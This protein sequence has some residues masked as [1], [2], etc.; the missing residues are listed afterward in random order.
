[1]AARQLYAII[2]Q[3]RTMV[4]PDESSGLPDAELLARFVALRDE[5]AFELLLWRHGPMVLGLCRRLLRSAEDVEDVFQA[6]FL[7]LA[8]KCGSIA[9][10][11][12][13]GSWLYKVAYRIALDVRTLSGRVASCE[14]QVVALPDVESLPD[15]SQQAARSEL[16]SLVDV[17]IQR[18]PR[19]YRD[20]VVLCHLQGKTQE[21]AA[22]ELG[23]AKGTVSTRLIRAR[24]LLRQRLHRHGEL[25]SAT[26][27]LGV[28]GNQSL[29]PSLAK[30]ALRAVF[31]LQPQATATRLA[32]AKPFVLAERVLRAIAL[33]Q[34]KIR[35]VGLLVLAL[36]TA[37]GWLGYRATHSQAEA[38]AFAH[39]A[40]PAAIDERA[41]DP[42]RASPL[43]RL[44]P[45]AIPPEDRFPWQPPELVAVLGEHR[46]RSWISVKGVACSPD[47]KQIA[48]YG[49]GFDIRLWDAATL[50]ER[51]VLKQH[52]RYISCLVFSPDGKVLA[53]GGQDKTL[54]LWDLTASPAKV[55]AVLTLSEGVQA[56]AFS[57][58]GSTLASSGWRAIRLWQLRRKTEPEQISLLNGPEAWLGPLMFS[59]DGKTLA[60]VSSD[61]SGDKVILW[62]LQAKTFKTFL[63]PNMGQI[64]C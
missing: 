15:V 16:Q 23:W 17:A 47:S 38:G 22:R 2:R 14:K 19:K 58:D 30:P 13:V 5:A 52:T 10:R 45:S 8:R 56:L 60:A 35:V 34:W 46:G 62:D 64:R 28:L 59:R 39:S 6:T 7:A 51:A 37:A 33:A 44:D 32:S 40:T 11:E 27:F 29:P 41:A 50:C 12:A 20:P 25:F 18:L 36:C 42:I 9:K 61:R 1:M 31:S 26:A 55:R 4:R 63:K 54:V 57:P 3:M 43:R 53:S 24:D 48:S 21:E 49:E